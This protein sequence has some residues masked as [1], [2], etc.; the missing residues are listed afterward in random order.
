MA[1]ACGL[2]VGEEKCIQDC[3]EKALKTK[4]IWKT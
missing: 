4:V 3:D 1:S 2:Y